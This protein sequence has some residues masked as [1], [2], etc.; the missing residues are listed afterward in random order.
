MS[1]SNRA[2]EH[3]S[4]WR[5]AGGSA[6]GAC[7]HRSERK[8]REGEFRATERRHGLDTV[9]RRRQWRRDCG[10]ISGTAT[11]TIEEAPDPNGSAVT[12]ADPSLGAGSFSRPSREAG[13]IALRTLFRLAPKRPKPPPALAIRGQLTPRLTKVRQLHL[14]ADRTVM[15]AIGT[16]RDRRLLPPGQAWSSRLRSRSVS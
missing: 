5:G 8:T 11:A 3:T 12:R 7:G 1:G 2:G 16:R 6:A 4:A 9:R 10:H 14:R 13:K 15:T